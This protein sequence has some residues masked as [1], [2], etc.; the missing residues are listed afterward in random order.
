MICFIFSMPP[1]IAKP[2]ADDG[3]DAET[4]RLVGEPCAQ[5]TVRRGLIG[6][7]DLRPCAPPPLCRQTVG[8][9]HMY[10][11]TGLDRHVERHLRHPSE[12]IF[13]VDTPRPTQRTIGHVV[14]GE[15][16]SAIRCQA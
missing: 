14:E 2:K 15:R 6:A 5:R 16:N 4:I 13:E 8:E 11:G 9:W 3:A 7:V 10:K 1:S 12:R